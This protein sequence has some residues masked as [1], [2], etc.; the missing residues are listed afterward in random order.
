M[1]KEKYPGL[2][3]VLEPHLE[4]LRAQVNRTNR[5]QF[6]V[7]LRGNER[8]VEDVLERLRDSPVGLGGRSA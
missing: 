3:T 1:A 6:K 5:R 4:D 7:W 8:I 2:A